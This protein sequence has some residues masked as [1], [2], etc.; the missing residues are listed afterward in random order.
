MSKKILVVD[1]EPFV[2]RSLTY[3]LTKNGYEAYTASDGDEA[4]KVLDKIKPDI[5]FLD[6]MMPKFSGYEVLRRIREN[7]DFDSIYIIMLS[8]KSQDRDREKSL[9]LGANEFMTKPFSPSRILQRINEIF[10]NMVGEDG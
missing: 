7:P 2:L 10:T 9:A 6:V 4:L 3:V 1:D 8:A 5:M